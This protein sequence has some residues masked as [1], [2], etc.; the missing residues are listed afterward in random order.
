M[1]SAAP[2]STTPT[3]FGAPAAS[4]AAKRNASRGNGSND[5]GRPASVKFTE[6]DYV[7]LEALSYVNRI[8]VTETVRAALDD[9]FAF[10]VKDP[11]LK[12]KIADAK[13][14]QLEILAAIETE[15][16][17]GIAMPP[18]QGKDRNLTRPMTIRLS[19]HYFNKCTAFALI[20]EDAPTVADQIRKAVDHYI[21]T[22]VG[23][24]RETFAKNF[25]SEEAKGKISQYIGV[26]VPSTVPGTRKRANGR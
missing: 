3:T 16:A 10:R 21:A 2:A 18:V 26:R 24:D 25:L 11:K 20:D 5:L 8:K 12:K 14:R 22:V 6:I 19:V 9:Y 17:S 1:N 13:K 7:C 15:D 4:L 23:F